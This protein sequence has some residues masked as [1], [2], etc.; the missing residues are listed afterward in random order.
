MPVIQSSL[1][2]AFAA[3]TAFGLLWLKKGS[4][5]SRPT[6]PELE[7][8]LSDLLPAAATPPPVPQD[9][10]KAQSLVAPNVH[11]FEAS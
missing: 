2:A 1:L 3:L 7:L 5:G 9:R 8:D 4:R 6:P 11:L 10:V